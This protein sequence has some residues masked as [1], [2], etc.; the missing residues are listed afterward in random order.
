MAA[1]NASYPIADLDAEKARL[2]QCARDVRNAIPSQQRQVTAELVAASGLPSEISSPGVVAGYYPTPREF[3]CLPLLHRLS[4]D[5]W[6][7]TLP[8][9]IGDVPLVFRRW[10]TGEALIKGQRGIM[11]PAGGEILR[12]SLL[13]MPLLAFDATGARLGYGGGHYDRTLQALRADGPILAVGLAFDEQE[14]AQ[15]PIDAHDQRLDYI[16]T[17]SGARRF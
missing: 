7:V 8:A 14:M 12:P 1:E 5:G 13:I 9:I 4:E 17:P 2:R 3:D 11:E 15:L 10:S 16:L 6:T